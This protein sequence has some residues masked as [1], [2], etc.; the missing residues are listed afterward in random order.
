VAAT[1]AR[2]W[3]AFA[4]A[5][6]RFVDETVFRTSLA[7]AVLRG[8]SPKPVERCWWNRSL[9]TPVLLDVWDWTDDRLLYSVLLWPSLE[10]PPEQAPHAHHQRV[11]QVKRVLV[12][13][14]Q[15]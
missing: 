10:A 11:K 3:H 2:V 14:A 15:S 4:D 9:E 6:G 13:G 1:L 7:W 12:A 5:F 8:K